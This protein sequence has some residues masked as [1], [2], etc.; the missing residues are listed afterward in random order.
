[1]AGGDSRA[2]LIDLLRN[3]SCHPDGDL[4]STGLCDAL[5]SLGIHVLGSDC[6]EFAILV[7]EDGVHEIEDD[8]EDS[9]ALILFPPVWLSRP[10]RNYEA[11]AFHWSVAALSKRVV[12]N[13]PGL[14]DPFMPAIL[15]NCK[16]ADE[17]QAVDGSFIYLNGSVI[18]DASAGEIIPES[19]VSIAT[20][21]N[22]F[23]QGGPWLTNGN[24]GVASDGALFIRDVKPWC[25]PNVLSSCFHQIVRISTT[26]P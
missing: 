9:I 11:L 1:M 25:D 14:S 12:I 23:F 4:S 22:N 10:T 16:T 17:E 15:V 20:A 5:A 7:Q 21:I 8:L 26:G 13:R 6:T 19:K 2:T 3:S 24:W 18:V